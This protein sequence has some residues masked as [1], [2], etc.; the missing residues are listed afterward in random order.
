M[1]NRVEISGLS[2]DRGIYNLIDEEIAPGTDIDSQ[3]FWQSLADICTELGAGNRALLEERD[4][5]Q[6]KLNEWHKTHSGQID[7]GQYKSFLREIGYMVEEGESFKV[8]YGSVVPG[9]ETIRSQTD[10][11]CCKAHGQFPLVEF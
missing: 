4:A 5:L 1:S 2:I 6:R 8:G 10:Y 9:C 7:S 3:Q 11:S